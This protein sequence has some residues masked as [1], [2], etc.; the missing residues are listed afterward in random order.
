MELNDEKVLND[1]E[2][3]IKISKDFRFNNTSIRVKDLEDILDLI[4]RLLE[5]N[6][7]LK[8][9]YREGLEQGKFDCQVKISELQ[10][11]SNELKKRLHMIWAIGVDY[12][13]CDGVESLKRLIDELVEITQMDGKEFLESYYGMEVE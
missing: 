3:A 11:Q 4:H 8:N 5:E 13:G 6:K 9:A 10:K 2:N 12:D 1:I 7:R